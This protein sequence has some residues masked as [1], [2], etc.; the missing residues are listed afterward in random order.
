MVALLIHLAPVGATVP[1]RFT[2]VVEYG[3]V[4]LVVNPWGEV[5]ADAGT[6]PGILLAEIETC[7]INAARSRIP[8]LRHTR[9][10]KVRP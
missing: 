4:K 9:D 5:I 10:V 7:A 2:Q 3:S 8:S 1:G 6:A